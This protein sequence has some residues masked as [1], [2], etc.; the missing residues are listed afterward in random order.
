MR[1]TEAQWNNARILYDA[2]AAAHARVDWFE[3]QRLA[4]LGWLTGSA[5]GRGSTHFFHHGGTEYVLR[6]YRRGGRVAVWLND[7]YLWTGLQDTRAW[8]EW[9]MLA[10]VTA[11]GLPA[12]RPFAARV[13]KS[14]LFY[15]ADLVTVRL[16]A[17]ASL[18]ERLEEDALRQE[19]WREIGRVIRRFHQAWVW[20]ADLNAHNVLLQTGGGI[21]LIDFD[22]ARIRRPAVRWRKANLGRLLRSLRKLKRLN[23]RLAFSEADFDWLRAGYAERRGSSKIRR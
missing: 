21:A 12:P 16:V 5:A 2:D 1:K 9:H 3:P 15:R 4:A 13:V 14:G 23:P 10:R 11:L 7:R 19:T 6:H 8:R 20:H 22:R 18:A 17:S